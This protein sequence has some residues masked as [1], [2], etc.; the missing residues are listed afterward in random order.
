MEANNL[1]LFSYA[2]CNLNC[3]YCTIDKNKYLKEVDDI[4]KD[5]FNN[6]EEQYCKRIKK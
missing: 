4:L 6:Y 2:M 5:S 3:I 1:I